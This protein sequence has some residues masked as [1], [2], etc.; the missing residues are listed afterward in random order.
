MDGRRFAEE[1]IR[2]QKLAD[3]GIS[4]G[5]ASSKGPTAGETKNGGGWSEVAKKGPVNG[6]KETEPTSA[7]KVVE[8]K[9]K[10]K[11]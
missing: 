5:S 6:T 2:R 4:E 11:K 1:F 9:K 7:F 10:G 8:P 3:R